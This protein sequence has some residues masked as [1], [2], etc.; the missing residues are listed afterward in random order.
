MRKTNVMTRRVAFS[1]ALVSPDEWKGI[2]VL[3]VK[4]ASEQ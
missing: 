3:I 2:V 1:Q 4:V